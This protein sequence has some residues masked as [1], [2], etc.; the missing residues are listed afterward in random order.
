MSGDLGELSIHPDCNTDYGAQ[1][2]YIGV[3][4]YLDILYN[5]ERLDLQKFGQETIIKESKIQSQAFRVS[6]ANT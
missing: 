5:S 6:E 1:R 4:I 3:S 2:D